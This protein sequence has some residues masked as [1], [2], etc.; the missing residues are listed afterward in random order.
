MRPSLCS[1]LPARPPDNPA[2]DRYNAATNT[3]GEADK[4][5]VTSLR[6]F[7][8]V[9]PERRPLLSREA[10]GVAAMTGRYKVTGIDRAQI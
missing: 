8:R 1:L 7:Y 10:Q 6:R 5:P 4:A 2:A 3:S 9:T